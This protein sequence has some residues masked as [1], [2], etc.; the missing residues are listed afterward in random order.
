[1]D[2]TTVRRAVWDRAAAQHGLVTIAQLRQIGLSHDDVA[3][4]VQRRDLDRLCV[5]VVR[6]PGAPP[7]DAQRLMAAVLSAGR[8]A[9]L[10]HTS[11]LAYWGVRGFRSDPLHV[12][13]HR[14]D[15]DRALPGVT[16]HEV[17]DLPLEHIRALGGIPVVS[18]PLALLQLS[19]MRGCSDAR[20]ALAI[21]A[22][23]NDRL[24]SY[25]GL[26]AIQRRMSKRGR[27]GLVRFRRIIEARGPQYVP[28]ASNLEG[29]FIEILSRAGRAPLRRQVDLG[30]HEHWIGRVDLCDPALPLVVEVQSE[31]FHSGLTATEHD[32]RRR[33]ELEAAGYEVVEV[34][35]E[36][37]FHRP[38]IAV[39][40]VDCG[41]DRARA[42]RKKVSGPDDGLP[43]SINPG[44]K[45]GLAHPSQTGL[46]LQGHDAQDV[47]AVGR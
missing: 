28:P 21:D 27:G 31:R 32:R 5:G 41:R 22:A 35:D 7:T 40:K 16:V 17:R 45:P 42:R 38:D 2:A 47:C 33:A 9:A 13:R 15:G 4:L 23:W 19:G 20:L 34:T 29:R 37:I 18:P 1:M 24:V 10:S 11:A 8:F 6:V 25:T 12:S 46:L 43:G 3:H 44:Q 26:V 30:D 36:E 14:D 39:A